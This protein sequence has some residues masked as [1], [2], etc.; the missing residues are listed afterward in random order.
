M[1][2][3]R[4]SR[5]LVT[6][7]A[8]AA[9][10]AV[11]PSAQA[12]SLD[13]AAPVTAVSLVEVVENGG[14]LPSALFPF[15]MV[16]ASF[17]TDYAAPGDTFSITLPSTAFAIIP[18]GS[19][20]LT[21]DDVSLASLSADASGQV[22]TVTFND[23]VTGLADISGDVYFLEQVT[24]PPS[25]SKAGGTLSQT[26]VA[27]PSSFDVA[28]PYTDLS[29][30]SDFR[31]GAYWTSPLGD[32]GDGETN[33]FMV[34]AMVDGNGA[35]ALEG[36]QW[37]GF[38]TDEVLGELST[39]A[40]RCGTTSVY[41]FATLPGTISGPLSGGV[42]LTPGVD[43]TVNCDDTSRGNPAVSVTIL[44]PQDGVFYGVAQGFD[45]VQRSTIFPA[46][47][48]NLPPASQV[49]PVYAY[50]WDSA[51]FDQ[52]LAGEGSGVGAFILLAQASGTATAS[53]THPGA[54][55]TLGSAPE[56]DVEITPGGDIV[57]TLTATNTGDVAILDAALVDDLSAL[58]PFAV[59][60]SAT[61]STGS[62]VMTSSTARWDGTLV[63]GE[64][65]SMTVT[66]RVN[67][68]TAG[69]TSLANLATFEGVAA[70][71]PVAAEPVSVAHRVASVPATSEP[72]QTSAPP[73]STAAGNDHG[74]IAETGS[75]SASLAMV[76]LGVIAIGTLGLVIAIRRRVV[77]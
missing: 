71:A 33:A 12:R 44:S 48:P 54:S 31:Y 56:A 74:T 27:G 38:S 28:A 46:S 34:N 20:V 14:A 53:M 25:L 57:Y 76:A 26:I 45:V 61:A 64:S 18:P 22:V 32:G 67:A 40:P 60:R 37:I 43:Y 58:M 65:I 4:F 19:Q 50:R 9:L 35:A 63:P 11:A 51:S 39:A 77:S 73:T 24:G 10:V 72:P 6:A 55:L 52:H 62:V 13:D 3:S 15:F 47:N 36:G 2:I 42:Q 30:A 59:V 17:H 49:I 21:D 66:I 1:L 75:D 16:K 69:G 29:G 5:A 68:D 41:Q 23:A 70:G 8:V 7:I